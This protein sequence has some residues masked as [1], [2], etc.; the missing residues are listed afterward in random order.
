MTGR[1]RNERIQS[2]GNQSHVGEQHRTKKP[3]QSH[4]DGFEHR[5]I[6]AGRRILEKRPKAFPHLIGLFVFDESTIGS[7]HWRS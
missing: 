6:A 2:V 5:Q 7:D 3:P 4:I 1:S